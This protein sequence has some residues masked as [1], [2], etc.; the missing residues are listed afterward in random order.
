MRPFVRCVYAALIVSVETQFDRLNLPVDPNT[1][2]P[3]PPPSALQPSY[4]GS[5]VYDSGDD[6]STRTVTPPPRWPSD[7]V[8]SPETSPDVADNRATSSRAS[9]SKS[10]PVIPVQV[11][12][13][14]HQKRL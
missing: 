3:S 10:P 6:G 8:H 12:K 7:S 14:P 1:I 13:T 5:Q 4:D 2:R 9:S 11:F